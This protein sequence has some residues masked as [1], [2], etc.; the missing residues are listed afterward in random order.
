M[1]QVHE[2][3]DETVLI[4]DWNQNKCKIKL[5][6]HVSMLPC[7]ACSWKHVTCCHK[8]LLVWAS[9]EVEHATGIAKACVSTFTTVHSSNPPINKALSCSMRKL[10]YVV[11]RSAGTG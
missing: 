9:L 1:A 10:I 5:K 2:N 3:F 4:Y 11:P 6:V 7:C 8:H